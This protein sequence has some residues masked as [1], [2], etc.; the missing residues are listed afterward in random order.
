MNPKISIHDTA[1]LQYI[2]EAAVSLREQMLALLRA[3]PE[4]TEFSGKAVNSAIKDVFEEGD[5]TFAMYVEKDDKR[6]ARKFLGIS[7]LASF[8]PFDT[9]AYLANNTNVGLIEYIEKNYSVE[10][11]T[12]DLLSF[13]INLNKEK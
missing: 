7:A 11:C 6:P 12:A 8:L 9:I 10:Q 3:L 2:E 4:E 5:F 1:A 13:M